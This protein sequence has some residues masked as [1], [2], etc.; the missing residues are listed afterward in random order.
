[1]YDHSSDTLSYDSDVGILFGPV[2]VNMISAQPEPNNNEIEL[3]DTEDDPWN[4]HL[5]M[6]WDIRFEQREPPIEDAL[7]QVNMGNETNQKPIY[8]SYTLSQSE[9]VDL[10]ALIREYIDVF[11]CHYEDMPGLDPKVAMHHLNIK[12]DAKPVKQPQRRFRPDIM[13]AI[14]KEVQKLIDSGFVCE[15][16]H[17]DWVANI[18]PVTQKN[19]SI[20]ICID[21]QN[22]NDAC[23]K[24]E[25]PLPVTDIMVDNTG[26]D[27]MMSFMDGF[28]GYNQIKMHPDD[29]RHTA[30]RTPLGV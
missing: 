27:E 10:I 24:D 30:F 19:G 20:R 9:M 17:P 14:E 26:D 15:E 18:V 2:S 5:N 11:A 1:M 28:S 23:P 8:I 16:Q 22:L 4:R 21:L 13:D 3:I 6:L 12:A 25:F 7:L 29:E